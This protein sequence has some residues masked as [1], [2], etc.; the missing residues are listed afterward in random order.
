VRWLQQVRPP[1]EG[2]TEPRDWVDD[3]DRYLWYLDAGG[4][5]AVR[6]KSLAALLSGLEPRYYANVYRSD[7]VP[8]DDP[9]GAGSDSAPQTAVPSSR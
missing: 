2:E 8:G 6:L 9:P 5:R 7:P 3:G 4:S 1:F